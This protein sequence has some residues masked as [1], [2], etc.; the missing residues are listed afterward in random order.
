MSLFSLGSKPSYTLTYGESQLPQEYISTRR[1]LFGF[2]PGREKIEMIGAKARKMSAE[3]EKKRE[4]RFGKLIPYEKAERA[5]GITKA[6]GGLLK[7]GLILFAILFL[8]IGGFAAFEAILTFIT[9]NLL[10][11]SIVLLLL[12]IIIMRTR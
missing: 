5:A 3:A 2:E 6:W 8:F 1:E 9:D 7:T 10:I 12:I 11:S 4:E